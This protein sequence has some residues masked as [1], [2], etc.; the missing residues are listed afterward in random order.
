MS[1]SRREFL[2]QTAA[3]IVGAAA[4]SRRAKAAAPDPAPTPIAGTPP[5]FGTAP[6]VG[7][8]VSPATFAEA[9]KLVR[10]E[11][12]AADRAQAAGQ[13][14]PRD[15]GDDGASHG[16]AEGQ[17][18]RLRRAG[19]AV[20]SPDP[21][22]PGLPARTAAVSFAAP[23]RLSPCP[24]NDDDIA[25]ATIAQQSHWIESK[26]LTSERLTKIYLDRIE[27]L[28]SEAPVRHHRD[29]RHSLWRRPSARTSRSRR[30]TTAGRST[31]SPGA[32][33]TCSTRGASGRRGAPSRTGTAFPRPTPRSSSASTRRAPCSWRSCRSE[34]S[35]STTSGSAD[36]R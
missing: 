18:R 9:E 8:E 36:R 10:Y 21:R 20:G 32:R 1:K 35:R 25:F 19:V 26:A 22:R 16:P 31:E 4:A 12:K 28:R 6:A 29:A 33:R 23:E 27:K 7:P 34:R 14:E 13:L 24:K 5:A 2:T 17:D 3:G 11:M 30:A 15:G